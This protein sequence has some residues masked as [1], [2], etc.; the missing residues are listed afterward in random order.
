MVI[1]TADFYGMPCC[2]AEIADGFQSKKRDRL[3]THL[4]HLGDQKNVK[5]TA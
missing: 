5:K 3:T 2:S 1:L 4:H